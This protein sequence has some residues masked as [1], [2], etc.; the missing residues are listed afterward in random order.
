MKLFG[1]KQETGQWGEEQAARYL[2]RKGYRI[3]ERNFSCRFGEIDLIVSD[4]DYIVFGEVK[5]RKNDTFAEAKEY[6]H[7]AKQQ[8][9]RST[10]MFWLAAHD[11]EL[12]PR[13]DVIEIYGMADT[14]MRKLDVRHIENAF[15]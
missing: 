6:V 2:K 1:F 7:A 14:P 9:V 10:A 8:R 11:T 3:L 5:T 13:F 15:E 12:Q 4:R